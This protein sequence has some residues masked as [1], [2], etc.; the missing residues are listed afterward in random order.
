MNDFS[1]FNLWNDSSH[2][3]CL[4]KYRASTALNLNFFFNQNLENVKIEYKKKIII[5]LFIFEGLVL[6]KILNKKSSQKFTKNYTTA[7]KNFKILKL[8]RGKEYKGIRGA[9]VGGNDA[10]EK[11]LNFW[12]VDHHWSTLKH[13]VKL[14]TTNKEK[15][16]KVETKEIVGN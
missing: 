3:F 16:R 15:A 2:R 5:K 12:K 14:E 8:Q 9:R 4:W 7:V 1:I 11:K 10:R 13:Q 6:N